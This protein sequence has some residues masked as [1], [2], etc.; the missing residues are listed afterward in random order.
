[1]LTAAV[2]GGV[3]AAPPPNHILHALRCVSRNDNGIKPEESF[4]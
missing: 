2:A 1:M 3:F 4:T